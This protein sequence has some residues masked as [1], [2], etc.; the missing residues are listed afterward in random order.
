MTEPEITT[1]KNEDLVS[2]LSN[3]LEQA[4]LALRSLSSM[5]LVTLQ[6]IELN[7][8]EA[9]ALEGIAM[10]AEMSGERCQRAVGS[11]A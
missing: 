2:E 9:R 6:G 5:A 8:D 1:K 4:A 7:T 3:E 10:F 11:S